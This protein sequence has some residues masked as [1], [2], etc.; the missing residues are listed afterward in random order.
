MGWGKVFRKSWPNFLFLVY[1]D[2]FPLSW[3]FTV[4]LGTEYIQGT[5]ADCIQQYWRLIHTSILCCFVG[6]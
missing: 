4:N 3:A 2:L 1:V 5:L 6:L